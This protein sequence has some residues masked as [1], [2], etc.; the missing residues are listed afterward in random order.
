MGTAMRLNYSR[1]GVGFAILNVPLQ[2]ERDRG[3]LVSGIVR[4]SNRRQA[5]EK[6]LV[7]A[8]KLLHPPGTDQALA[9]KEVVDAWRDPESASDEN[10][11]T[12]IEETVARQVDQFERLDRSAGVKLNGDSASVARA[13]VVDFLNTNCVTYDAI[14]GA[15]FDPDRLVVALEPRLQ[16]HLERVAQLDQPAISY[17]TKFFGLVVRQTV[18]IVRSSAPLAQEVTIRNYLSTTRAGEKLSDAFD[19]IFL[20]E[21]RR[22]TTE[23]KALF[24]AS[25]F[26]ALV[27]R[28]GV[29]RLLGLEDVPPA[30]STAPLDVTYISLDATA[31][32]PP[33]L[34]GKWSQSQPR[35]SATAR[36][37]SS[38]RTVEEVMG[39]L[40][41]LLRPGEGLRL[42][43]SGVA[44]SGKTTLAH[45]LATRTALSHQK[46]EALPGSLHAL[47][48]AVPFIVRL[49]SA[50]REDGSSPDTSSLLKEI[51]VSESRPGDWLSECLS[52]GR[53]VVIFDGLDEV[54]PGRLPEAREWIAEMC[55]AYPRAHMVVTGRPESVDEGYLHRHRFTLVG[56]NGLKPS[57]SRMVI[58][59]WF[60][61]QCDG[62]PL[63]RAERYRE[64]QARLVHALTTD[65]SVAD[66]GQT[67]LLASVLAVY[68]VNNSADRPV[69]RLRL[70]EGVCYT[71]V[72]GREAAKNLTPA[73]MR[74]FGYEE[75]LSLLGQ[76]A[77]QMFEAGV[78]EVSV[79]SPSAG[80]LLA[81]GSSTIHLELG[82]NSLDPVECARYLL[83]R[84]TI[85]FSPAPHAATFA[86]RMFLEFVAARRLVHR[87]A[88]K[89]LLDAAGQPGWY[90]VVSFFAASAADI[91][92]EELIADLIGRLPRLPDRRRS[93]YTLAS[94][95]ASVSTDEA[96]LFAEVT[97]LVQQVLPPS[98]EEEVNLL[99]TMGSRAL[100]LLPNPDSIHEARAFLATCAKVHTDEA[101]ELIAEMCA[102]V[103]RQELVE[104]ALLAW[105]SFPAERY[106]TRVLS[107]FD[108]SEATIR[109]HS[110]DA[111]RAVRDLRPGHLV[112]EACEGLTDLAWLQNV[113]GLRKL[114][115][116]AT[117]HVQSLEGLESVQ[118]SI[119]SLT[120]PQ[121]GK[122]KELAPLASASRLCEIRIPQARDIE[123]L[124]DLRTLSLETVELGWA[125]AGVV[126]DLS[127]FEGTLQH[128]SLS[129]VN[130]V[131][132]LG[133]RFPR[134]HSVRIAD[135]RVEAGIDLSGSTYVEQV[136]LSIVVEGGHDFD[137]TLPKDGRVRRLALDVTSG[138]AT[139]ANL[140]RQP[141]LESLELS[142]AVALEG[143][144][145][146]NPWGKNWHLGRLA[147]SSN[148]RQL[149]VRESSFLRDAY[150][151]HLLGS[152]EEL[153]LTGASIHRLS[154]QYIDGVELVVHRNLRGDF[155]VDPT[156]DVEVW[157]ISDCPN[158]RRLILDRC[159]ELRELSGLHKCQ[160]LELV[161]LRG[162][163][164]EELIEN[165]KFDVPE[166]VE[167]QFDHE[168]FFQETG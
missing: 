148:L 73:H 126:G 131:G 136:A 51:V 82:N 150:G 113:S 155:V 143:Q 11:H 6:T 29:T 140:D 32:A 5:A 86:H 3:A 77:V 129:H 119:L 33:E 156:A 80:E 163:A 133:V 83:T 64:Q 102:R 21:V 152:L 98:D 7:T 164:D 42:S 117:A 132:E 53:A 18:G 168:L 10:L 135:S 134:L 105:R 85:F 54:P 20:P 94:C 91:H 89:R 58:D 9:I 41:S 22:G 31:P 72:Y 25:Y 125:T 63:A 61:A 26:E 56:L 47:A 112:L 14:E 84:S 55:Q 159:G 69:A 35:G 16:R 111:A 50:Y 130:L 151:V 4:K 12:V 40:L 45:W 123:Q 114:D 62:I 68:Y 146:S 38:S 59:R 43:I 139:I 44:G 88:M 34:L 158:L 138:Q 2:G 66:L 70:I 121:N 67:P 71:L 99:A 17:A 74:A 19:R 147:A 75:R 92:T 78:S 96:A 36:F 49:R 137:L 87:G 162:V 127:L 154:G 100:R 57:Q 46:V 141:F 106:A 118:E 37:H 109:L 157:G 48:F 101:L 108:C 145:V 124:R 15:E 104:D 13:A 97:D 167:V 149:I 79:L 144:S 8:L 65:P 161:S 30:L 52:S 1:A 24:E 110:A 116:Q 107:Q 93:I 166:G 165:V 27:R 115:L 120:L 28:Y 76:I 153:D 39:G 60:D 90:S 160:R 23:E 128:I 122:V 103:D 81:I 142:G 95:M